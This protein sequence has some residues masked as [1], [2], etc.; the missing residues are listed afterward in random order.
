MKGVYAFLL[1]I[2]F[3]SCTD[4]VTYEKPEDLI[5]K[6]EM[7]DLLFEM[8]IVVGTSNI[9]NLHLEKNRNYMSI[10]FEKYGV[11]STRFASSNLYY[12]SNIVEYEEIYEEVER[13]LDT[14]KRFHQAIMDSISGV[15]PSEGYEAI[16]RD[17]DSLAK[18]QKRRN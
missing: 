11:D 12:T 4:K 6:K 17:M 14:L 16:K 7:T 2:L 1:I 18:V 3:W 10:L 5:G 9:K 13:R 15:K 8:H